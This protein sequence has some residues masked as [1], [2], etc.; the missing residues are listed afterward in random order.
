MRQVERR[1]RVRGRAAQPGLEAVAGQGREVVGTD[2]PVLGQ[3]VDDLDGPAVHG[4]EPRAQRLVPEQ[5]RAHAAVQRVGVERTG[6]AQQRVDVVRGLGSQ[7]VLQPETLLVERQ[8]RLGVRR[9]APDDRPLRRSPLHHRDGERGDRRV[10]EE[11][12]RRDADPPRLPDPGDHLDRGQRVAVEFEEVVV[13]ADVAAV[14]GHGPDLGDGAFLRCSRE[15][16]RRW[17]GL[18]RLHHAWNARQPRWYREV[19]ERGDPPR[20]G[21]PAAGTGAPV[22]SATSTPGSSATRASNAANPS[23]KRAALSSSSAPGP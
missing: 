7:L 14:Q 9:P 16:P 2:V 13:D 11:E 3:L 6:Q 15:H 20:H 1:V 21:Q 17:R 12:R 23:T 22:R 5:D 8:H 10:L 19:A 18:E 4:R